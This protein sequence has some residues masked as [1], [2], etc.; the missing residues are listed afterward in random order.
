MLRKVHEDPVEGVGD[1]QHRPR[2]SL[3][4][5]GELERIVHFGLMTARHDPLFP[6]H[7]RAAR[8]DPAEIGSG[9]D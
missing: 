6:G 2:R 3:Q 5:I 7:R 9:S 1:G 4:K 8:C